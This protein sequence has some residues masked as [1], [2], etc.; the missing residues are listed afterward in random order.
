MALGLAKASQFDDLENPLRR[1]GHYV[2]PSLK[3]MANGAP[4]PDPAPM[5]RI[6][7]KYA[8]R[9]HGRHRAQSA[10]EA[11]QALTSVLDVAPKAE[12]RPGPAAHAVV[13]AIAKSFAP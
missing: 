10:Q 12:R 11:P 2:L 1:P 7:R 8:H 9:N 5:R 3:V 4:H 6:H 13:V